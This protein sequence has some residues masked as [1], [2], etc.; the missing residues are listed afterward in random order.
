MDVGDER[1][2]VVVFEQSLADLAAGLGFLAALDGDSDE[3]GAGVDA[4]LDLLDRGG[5][6]AGV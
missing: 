4:A 2:G 6:V 1:D 5:D 3:L